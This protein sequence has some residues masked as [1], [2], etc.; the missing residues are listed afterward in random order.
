GL[1]AGDIRPR[2]AECGDRLAQ[3]VALRSVL[4]VVDDG[5]FA[6]R[7]VQGVVACPGLGAWMALRN[8][9]DF[10]RTAALELLGDRHGL[11]I[12][13]LDDEF[14]I[15]TVARIVEQEQGACQA[16]QDVG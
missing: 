9:D 8:A 13:C 15:E 12:V 2:S 7:E 6:A 5:E 10:E 14:Y 3:L 11:E 1:E 16:R 4:G